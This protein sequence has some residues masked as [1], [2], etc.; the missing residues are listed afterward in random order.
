[1]KKG[2]LISMRYLL[3]LIIVSCD[4]DDV[5]I[6]EEDSSE[7]PYILFTQNATST[8]GFLT[9]FNE[10]PAGDLDIV[11]QSN[12]IS[13]ASSQGGIQFKNT[14]FARDKD[15]NNGLLKYVI[16]E[17]G[18]ISEVG[19]IDGG[20]R[21]KAVVVSD[22]KG[23][24]ADFDAFNIQIFNPE[25]MQRTGEVDLSGASQGGVIEVINFMI[26]RDG[27]LFAGFSSFSLTGVSADSVYLAVVD[28]ATD[29]LEATRIYPEALYLGGLWFR[30]LPF[31][32]DANGD[33]YMQ[34]LG[35]L[36]GATQRLSKILRIKSGETDFDLTY[37]W[38][39]SNT[40]PPQPSI[41]RGLTIASNGKA[42][43]CL[44][45]ETPS[46]TTGI[47]SEPIWQYYELDLEN[48]TG[49]LISDIPSFIGFGVFMVMEMNNQ[50]LFPVISSSF[51]GYYAM[52]MATGTV[53]QQ[54]KLTS[55]GAPRS[56]LKID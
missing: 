32:T 42:Y 50:L 8:D 33:L 44:Q 39:I 3:L 51:N 45:T 54:F 14:F 53:Q 36:S 5:Q 11:S 15:G 2:N 48:K 26:E 21:L 9:A 25:T 43:T 7:Y 18:N 19:F 40:L 35:D 6:E 13:L 24:Y 4:N 55:G 41:M 46:T 37:E 1:M 31:A 27:K 23:Y 30:T 38:D 10:L 56:F 17:N 29:Q 16:D 34:A 12:V 47:F 28:I 52:D 22:T 49:S 20:D